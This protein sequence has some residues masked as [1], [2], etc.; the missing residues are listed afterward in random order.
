[1]NWKPYFSSVSWLTRATVASL[2]I[3]LA[4]LIECLIGGFELAQQRQ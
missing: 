2:G 4:G 1:M 3:E